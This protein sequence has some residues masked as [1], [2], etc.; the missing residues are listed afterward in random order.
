MFEELTPNVKCWETKD[1]QAF[2]AFVVFKD[3]DVVLVDPV[4]LDA[5]E[6]REL[7]G[8]GTVRA[9]VITGDFHEREAPAF[10]KKFGVP[11]Y[12]HQEALP[13]LVSK[14]VQ[15]LPP[16]LPAGLEAIYMP[17]G[18]PG[19]IVLYQADDGGTLIAGDCW[20][21]IDLKRVPFIFRLVLQ[22]VIKLRDGLHPVPIK[23]QR[24]P[25]RL[26]SENRKLLER[27]IER[28]LVSHG[29]AILTGAGALMRERIE[30]GP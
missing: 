30:Q 24:D 25:Q 1:F 3:G 11:V 15:P 5:D 23:R 10:G 18:K 4:A 9:I 26:A 29:D 21:N 19:E 14:D 28:L 17:G 20:H 13:G 2:R 6:E 7:A 12:A 8:L 27:P 16:H 22:G